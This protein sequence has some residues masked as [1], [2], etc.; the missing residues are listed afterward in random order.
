MVAYS[1]VMRGDISTPA[2]RLGVAKDSFEQMGRVIK[3]RWLESAF[4]RTESEDQRIVDYR[5]SDPQWVNRA[6][7][8]QDPAV[9]FPY[10]WQALRKKEGF[11][12]EEI[13][14]D[15]SW[16]TAEGV[17]R[18]T[19]EHGPAISAWLEHNY[20]LPGFDLQRGND[21]VLERGIAMALKY[22]CNY[23]LA[24]WDND[25][26]WWGVRYENIR[27]EDVYPDWKGGRWY[28]IRTFEP[29]SRIVE[30]AQAW[31][32]LPVLD[33]IT[34]VEVQGASERIARNAKTLVEEVEKG[35][36]SLHRY[37]HWYSVDPNRHQRDA[38]KVSD[39]DEYGDR[40]WV[41]P[42]DDPMSMRV[43]LLQFIELRRG[44]RTISVVPSMSQT[45]GDLLFASSRAPYKYCQLVPFTPFPV[46][47]EVN[48]HSLPYIIGNL[49][50]SMSWALRAQ[51]RFFAR[52]ADPA[53][54]FRSGTKLG[55]RATETLSNR[56][57]EVEDPS[58][59]TILDAPVAN[60]GMHNMA[61]QLTKGIADEGAGESEERRGR[62]SKGTATAV[63]RASNASRV[64]DGLVALALKQSLSQLS[65]V[66]IEIMRVHIDHERAIAIA[67]L[68]GGQELIEIK[69]EFVRG[70]YVVK[71]KGQ[72]VG[73][74]PAEK[75]AALGEAF[76][77][78]G[79]MVLNPDKT[80][81]ELSRLMGL[82][83]A[84]H[85]LQN[86]ETRKPTTP[87]DEHVE[88]LANG[89]AVRP[90]PREN[91]LDHLPAHQQLQSEAR[92]RLAP[93]HPF[94]Q[95]IQDHIQATMQLFQMMMPSANMGGGGG[96][97][98][99]GPGPGA[100]PPVGSD[101][102]G[103]AGNV[104]TR[105]AAREVQQSRQSGG[106]AGAQTPYA[107]GR[108]AAVTRA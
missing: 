106:A 85:L 12:L 34:G 94:H 11:L 33:P 16:R 92:Q 26:D 97:I 9:K 93:D 13:R 1:S 107:P 49:D 98:G 47:E 60:T 77:R 64:D 59:I 73:R 51:L 23:W 65:R 43:P 80:F 35:T 5:R 66:T 30:R 36:A 18:D 70:P 44:G 79:P 96:A 61:L 54:L 17:A 19:M 4:S 56:R 52:W 100:A 76:D 89:R 90:S 22:S 15:T 8:K 58:D 82:D 55:R 46:D 27:W 81:L 69:P 78:F 40:Y 42:S 48:G 71:I 50:E 91:P 39:D 83:N 3:G 67:G 38:G 20:S 37:D 105:D 63:S 101:P 74:D 6:V 21:C 104:Q 99:P 72:L 84:R 24:T 86:L 41:S 53:I 68:D 88:M 57:I 2:A 29:V 75:A 25:P 102:V 95:L 103:G 45:G 31:V 32:E 14:Q 87:D 10:T 28:V 108:Q 62:A 7:V